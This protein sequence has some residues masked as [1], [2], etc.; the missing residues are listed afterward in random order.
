MGY[1]EE[2]P[3]RRGF[4]APMGAYAERKINSAGSA[5]LE[6]LCAYGRMRGEKRSAGGM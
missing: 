3:K 4:C 1:N 5:L 2:K 6:L